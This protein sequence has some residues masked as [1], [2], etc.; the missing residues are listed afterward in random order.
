[1]SQFPYQ[2]LVVVGTTSSGK[3]TLASQLVKKISAD[4]IKLDTLHW[5]EAPDEMFR[6]RVETL[7]AISSGRTPKPHHLD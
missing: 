3:S 6:E 4:F 5:V 2:R 7:C 1:M